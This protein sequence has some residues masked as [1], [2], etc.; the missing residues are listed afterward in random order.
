MSR[1]SGTQLFSTMARQAY[2]IPRAMPTGA[3]CS[4]THI[5]SIS[6]SIDPFAGRGLME[7]QGSASRSTAKHLDT[8]ASSLVQRFWTC[9]GNILWF[10]GFGTIAGLC[11]G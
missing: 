8:G 4:S 1:H 7:A 11:M 2:S 3:C 9:K 10:L 5:N 6:C